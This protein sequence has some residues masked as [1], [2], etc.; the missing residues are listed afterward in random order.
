M[1]KKK[2]YVVWKGAKTGI[3][4]TWDECLRQVSGFDGA[5][6]KSFA[7]LE[8]AEKAFAENPWKHIGKEST[9]TKKTGQYNSPVGRPQM[10]SISVDAAWNT[11]SKDM[12]YQGVI[13]ATGEIIFHQGPYRDGTNNIGE[14]LGIV[15]GLAW[16][17]QR[18]SILPIYTDSKTAISW[19]S[20]KKA[21]TKLEPT[22]HNKVLFELLERAEKW[23]RENHWDNPILKWHTD[24]WGEIPADFGRK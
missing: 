9:G 23:L 6:Y 15:H 13:T 16:L 3:F 2:F 11:V 18:G 10:N 19:V 14:F 17:K 4:E 20:R 7:G 1:A 24:V 21:K 8:E 5:L 12:E 22:D